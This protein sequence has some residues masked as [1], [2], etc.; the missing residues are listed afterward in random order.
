MPWDP[1]GPE[2]TE[3]IGPILKR[4]R[5]QEPRDP[6]EVIGVQMSHE[7]V[8]DSEARAVTHHLAL[9]SLATIEKKGVP[10]PL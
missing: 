9:R 2:D 3:R 6:E 5:P 10:L 8:S 7:N 1:E 4:H